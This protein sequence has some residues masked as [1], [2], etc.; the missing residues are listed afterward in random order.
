M[1]EYLVVGTE[2]R[3]GR[4]YPPFLFAAPTEH[5]VLRLCRRDWLVIQSVTVYDGKGEGEKPPLLPSGPPLWNKAAEPAVAA[6]GQNSGQGTQELPGKEA[7]AIRKPD[8]RALSGARVVRRRNE[9]G[10][11]TIGAVAVVIGFLLW[12]GGELVNIVP[13]NTIGIPILAIGAVLYFVGRRGQ[14]P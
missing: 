12:F 10:M 3:T 5:D 4:S 13:Y 7:E 6:R 8:P 2:K 1:P 9:D 11:K 14:K